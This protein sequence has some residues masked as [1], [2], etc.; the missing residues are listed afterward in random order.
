[1]LP[2]S[3][4]WQ[5]ATNRNEHVYTNV[6]EH[7]HVQE[8]WFRTHNALDVELYEY[9]LTVAKQRTDELALHRLLA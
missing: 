9:I 3:G 1:M 8:E 6:K 5:A 7:M 2:D 4:T